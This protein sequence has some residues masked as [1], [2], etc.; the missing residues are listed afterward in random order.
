QIA[1][2]DELAHREGPR[3]FGRSRLGVPQRGVNGPFV[4]TR[5]GEL[6][7]KT[8]LQMIA[9]LPRTGPRRGHETHPARTGH[10]RLAGQGFG[11]AFE[12]LVLVRRGDPHVPAAPTR[13]VGQVERDEFARGRAPDDVVVVEAA[14]GF[15]QR[16][17]SAAPAGALL[18]A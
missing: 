5:P 6:A 15:P 17:P 14:H 1:G 13:R 4:V 9:G 3:E 8:R 10:R 7:A 12:E 18:R 11:A 2:Y 16:V